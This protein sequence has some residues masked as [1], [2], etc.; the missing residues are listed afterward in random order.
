[1]V[2]ETSLVKTSD[3]RA[4][5]KERLA[6]WVTSLSAKYMALFAL[7]VAVPVAGTAAYLLDSSYNDNK[8]ALIGVQQEKASAIAARLSQFFE[9]AASNLAAVPAADLPRPALQAVLFA[10][11]RPPVLESAYYD[12]GGRL[13]L[14]VSG[15]GVGIRANSSGPF[16][17]TLNA[18]V[19]RRVEANGSFVGAPATERGGGEDLL[20]GTGFA[21][22][23]RVAAEATG[24]GTVSSTI[25][26]GGVRDL[27]R[28][29]APSG[30]AYVYVVDRTGRA[31]SYPDVK[32]VLV[33]TLDRLPQVRK[34]LQH[35]G[36]GSAVGESLGHKK[37]LSA[38]AT[39]A[40]TGW[41][42]FVEEP[43]SEAFAP[44]QGKIWR[45]ALLLSA[46]V[47]AGV[48]LSLL[49]ARRLVR[50]I[51]RMQV[52]A[53]RI[54]GGDYGE[55]IE[56]DRRDEL[57]ALAA[58]FNRMAANL[59][60]L[61]SGLEQKVRERT[62]ELEVASKH[63]SDFLANMS[64]ELRTPL[65]AI[66]GF[67]QVL[68]EKLFG[69]VNEKQEEYLDDILSSANHLLDLINDILDLSKVEAGQIELEHE[70]F[71]LRDA[72]ERGIVMVRE[73]AANHGVELQLHA[74]GAEMV[75]GD[76]RR[77]RQVIFNLLSNAVK[78]TP[79]GGRVEV[80]TEKQDGEVRVLVADTGPGIAPED[81]E[82]IFEEFQQTET[83]LERHEGTGLG[84]A[85]SR[86]LI[87]LHGGRIWVESEPG[88]GSMFV[89]TLPAE[90]KR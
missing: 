38:W 73:R 88:E 19:R 13:V 23:I 72:L 54:G 61:I 70:M 30:A 78:F 49:L 12:A 6:G 74:D 47:L 59:Q 9:D 2:A 77:I 31:L 27:I 80:R 46:F 68:R 63:K 57:G 42:V 86:R 18:I 10:L 71:S 40:P 26:L 90:A 52:V 87:E 39:V 7:L 69:P 75:E 67:S 53:E 35:G 81:H 11:I 89:F 37:V 20:G 64:H 79:E 8:N 85:L 76:E 4:A 29:S 15:D 24:G 5:T 22:T 84:L 62:R 66:V 43:E 16:D 65:N 1:M 33:R 32:G 58:S 41:K 82:R 55:R 44:L 21:G 28:S 14:G 56:L 48:V 25:D 83:G 51:T 3:K 36:G 34:S 50:R 45:T 60:E 17:P